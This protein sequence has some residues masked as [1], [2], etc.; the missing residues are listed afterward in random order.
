MRRLPPLSALS[1]FEATVRL[2]S[3]T[4]AADELGR[5]HSA[6]SKQLRHLAEDLGVPLFLKDGVGLKPTADATELA[7]EVADALDVLDGARRRIVAR[8]DRA[9]VL[10]V[11]CSATLAM[12]WVVPRLPRFYARHPEIEI[13]LNL[14][15]KVDS[16]ADSEFDII[17][18]CER[19]VWPMETSNAVSF[20][21][22]GLGLVVSPQHQWTVSGN[23]VE[24]ETRIDHGTFGTLWDTWRKYSGYDVRGGHV[25]SYPHM[26]LGLEVAGAG[27][28]ISLADV[29]YVIDDI[30]AG[31]LEAPFG[32]HRHEDGFKAVLPKARRRPKSVG[33]FIDWI[34]EEVQATESAL[35]LQMD[36]KSFAGGLGSK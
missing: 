27:G 6:I 30:I 22:S 34:A 33:R 15:Q 16:H 1:A 8:H 14:S 36:V 9:N 26:F 32:F 21:H 18:T 4:A 28:G 31:R 25:Q 19:A 35:N 20:G 10:R 12:R 13:S 17:L 24:A 7:T 23:V 29:H 3:V 5:T 2:G 11:L